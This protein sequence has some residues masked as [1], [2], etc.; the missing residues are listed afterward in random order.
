MTTSRERSAQVVYSEVHKNPHTGRDCSFL[1][2]VGDTEDAHA[3]WT[4]FSMY[5]HETMI[6]HTEEL[7]EIFEREIERGV[8]AGMERAAKIADERAEHISSDQY[9]HEYDCVGPAEGASIVAD[10]IRAAMESK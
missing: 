3:D 8:R 6:D 7:R 10:A 4:A 2:C 1:V 5:N 9:R